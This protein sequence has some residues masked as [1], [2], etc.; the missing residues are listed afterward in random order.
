MNPL[1]QIQRIAAF[2]IHDPDFDPMVSMCGALE[3]ILEI[4][5][6]PSPWSD[7]ATPSVH[8]NRVQINAHLRR[9]E[10]IITLR[11][12]LFSCSVRLME[13][14]M[15]TKQDVTNEIA[16]L[17]D[18]IR[19]DTVNDQ[20]AVDRLSQAVRDLNAKVLALQGQTV[21]PTDFDDIIQQIESVKSMVTAVTL[22]PDVT[23][24]TPPSDVPPTDVP[25]GETDVPVTGPTTPPPSGE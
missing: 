20:Q 19:Q 1:H 11:E 18:L 12:A 15:A 25:P 10:H 9:L 3:D 13:N 8:S 24:A 17:R 14:I 2:A 16:A 6:R 4:A 22:P 23:P 21:S 7:D 5:S